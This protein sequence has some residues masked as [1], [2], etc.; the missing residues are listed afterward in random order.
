MRRI[1]RSSLFIL[2]VGTA[3]GCLHSRP[4]MREYAIADIPAVSPDVGSS[5]ILAASA[6]PV[7]ASIP[8]TSES[9]KLDIP[10]DLPG[11]STPTF[12]LPKMAGMTAEQ[13]AQTI[14]THF[15]QLPAIDPEPL[16]TGDALALA[17]LEQLA[18]ANN[19]KVKQAAAAVE[20]ARGKMIQAGLLPN[21]EIGYQSDQMNSGVGVQTRGQQG[22]FVGWEWITAG[23][24]SLARLAESMAYANAQVALRRTQIDVTVAVRQQYFAVLVAKQAIR[25]N[26]ALAT[27]SDEIYTAQLGLLQ[28]GELAGYEPLQSYVLAVQARGTLTQARNRYTSAWRQLAAV[29]GT[30]DLP[31]TELAGYADAPAPEYTLDSIRELMLANHTDLQTAQNAIVEA[32]YRLRLAEVTPIP[33]LKAQTYI[34]K[35]WSTPPYNTQVGVQAGGAIPVFNRN[36]GGRLTARADLARAI[37]DVSRVQNDLSAQL[38]QSWE[39]YASNRVLIGYYR[40]HVIPNQVRVYRGTFER[41]RKDPQSINYNDVVVAQ[42]TLAA[43]LSAYLVS[44]ADQWSAVTNLTA[45]SQ[46]P[47]L[48]PSGA[49]PAQSKSLDGL[50]APPPPI[51]PTPTEATSKPVK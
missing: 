45:L 28:A 26:R 23:K 44:L 1:L 31:Q 22:A 39:V 9:K 35:D 32:R 15:P 50:L 7:S 20:A 18:L 48:Y 41:F 14:Q 5:G 4:D 12:S 25:V 21:P 36:Q 8:T 11:A 38:A 37:Q 27:F 6:P 30:P 40:D 33:N 13:R 3:Q 16:A 34:E 10:A 17:D 46:Q 19:P 49:I 51:E 47:E 2:G 42:Q 43:A 24:L 29:M